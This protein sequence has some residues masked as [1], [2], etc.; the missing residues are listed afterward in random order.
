MV[1][2]HLQHGVEKVHGA[3]N[4]NSSFITAVGIWNRCL[5]LN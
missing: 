1:V 4:E 3:E 2:L 5:C